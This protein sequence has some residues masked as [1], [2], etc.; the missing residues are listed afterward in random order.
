MGVPKMR[1]LSLFSGG[2][3]GVLASHLLGWEL[4][5]CA[6]WDEGARAILKARIEDGSIP[7]IPLHKDVQTLDPT[8]YIG[9]V[10][11]VTG[12]FPCQPFSNAGKKMGVDDPRNMWPHTVRILKGT[13]APFGYFENVASLLSSGYFG[14][15]LKDLIE[16][17][18]HVS[19]DCVPA[20]AVG[21]PHIR[22]RLWIFARKTKK[23]DPV[24]EAGALPL[25]TVATLEEGNWQRTTGTA[26]WSETDDLGEPAKWPRAGVAIGNIAHAIPRAG[27][28][29]G[30]RKYGVW[31]MTRL[32]WIPVTDDEKAMVASVWPTPMAANG[33]KSSYTWRTNHQNDLNAAVANPEQHWATPRAVDAKGASLPPSE[34][35]RDGVVGDVMRAMG[36]ED[37]RR[38]AKAEWPTPTVMDGLRVAQVRTPEQIEAA[39]KDGGCRNLRE[40]AVWAT[41]TTMDTLP[42]KSQE[43]LDREATEARAGRSK[44]AN[45]RDQVNVDAGNVEWKGREMYPTPLAG[46]NR[47]SAKSLKRIEEGGQSTSPGLAQHAE[48][49]EGIIP[50]EYEGVPY[51]ELPPKVKAMWPTPTAS[52][53]KQDVN[54]SGEYAERVQESGFQQAL[55]VAV[56]LRGDQEIFPTP[57][58]SDRYHPHME[59]NEDGVPH[60][61]AKRNLRGCVQDPDMWPTPRTGGGSRP[62]G[63]GG[64]VLSEEVQ[65]AEGTRERGE[66]V[67]GRTDETFPTP[68]T[69]DAGRTGSAEAWKE[70]EEE[71]KTSGAR[72]RNFTQQFPTPCAGTHGRSTYPGRNV[73]NALLKGEEPAHQPLTIDVVMYEELK[74]RGVAEVVSFKE[75]LFIME[76]GEK[77]MWPTPSAM[78][79]ARRGKAIDPDHWLKERDKHAEKGVN[80][81]FSLDVA[82]AFE[83]QGRD[84]KETPEDSVE[85]VGEA[86]AA[87]PVEEMF[88]MFPTPRTRGLRGGSKGSQVAYR[89][90]V[91]EGMEPQEARALCGIGEGEEATLWP[92]PQ[93][94]R[95]LRGGS[96][97]SRLAYERLVEQGVDPEEA[98][99]MLDR[100]VWPTP[101]SSSG[102]RGGSNVEAARARLL[103]QGHDPEEV[104][105]MLA[106]PSDMWPTP[107]ASDWKGANLKEGAT[108]ASATGLASAANKRDRAQ[109]QT[110]TA[111]DAKAAGIDGFSPLGRQLDAAPKKAGLLNPEWVAW[112]MGWPVGWTSPDPMPEGG[113]DSWTNQ[114]QQRIWW[115]KEPEGLPRLTQKHETAGSRTAR[116]KALGNGQVSLCCARSYEVLRFTL[117][118]VLAKV[119]EGEEPIS[120]TDFLRF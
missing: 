95:G 69:E 4:K 57:T 28:P 9:E 16:A 72:L 14:T 44:A 12:G 23:S 75:G 40:E 71:G 8:E 42:P 61:V 48:L 100:D 91:G 73:V 120:L 49:Q 47:K 39:K 65:I 5:G 45:L 113:L 63:K 104:E 118:E 82:V 46:E 3:G 2:G 81:H 103:E 30:V 20:S 66:Y 97:G 99:A 6:E 32:P 70:Y 101:N 11:I 17:G 119:K 52:M 55:P 51:E 114:N 13:E 43:V 62:N 79:G 85:K 74:E 19:W 33:S 34:A 90:L 56:K 93:A 109:F 10:D 84:P 83:D 54:D 98:A 25:L 111:S 60:D 88:S 15:I 89:R 86:L 94:S 41:P 117:D 105:A 26:T 115:G 78:D 31:P 96:K 7:D 24:V 58:T 38:G 80:K 112:L 87:S 92:T 110:P 53:Y 29:K 116:L 108:S 77:V 35:G 76:D 59:R 21:A 106:K 22:D 68:T 37:K 64:K 107:L 27:F 50:R 102:L 36:V 18:F 1:E 67:D